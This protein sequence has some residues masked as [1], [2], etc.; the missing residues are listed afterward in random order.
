ML[1][2]EPRETV[3]A[4]PVIDQAPAPRARTSSRG[5]LVGAIAS[6]L[7]ALL[8]ATFVLQLWRADLSQ[9]FVY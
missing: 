2:T 6:V 9:P 5:A 7:G 8:I 1:V 4:P 3:V